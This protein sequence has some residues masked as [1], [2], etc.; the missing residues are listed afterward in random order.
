[1]P[2]KKSVRLAARWFQ[3][4]A[5]EL[6]AFASNAS[7]HLSAEHQ[8]W[9]YEYAI[10]RLYR[11]FEL[12]MLEGIVG[13]INN[14]TET[15]SSNVG[16]PFPTHLT[17]EV[18]E[19]LVLGAGYFDFKGRDGLIRQLRRFVPETH[20]L[21]TL[22]R[23]IKYKKSLEQLSGL[24]NFAAHDSYQ[25]KKAAL[26]AVGLDRIGSAGSWLKRQGRFEQIVLRLKELSQELHDAAPY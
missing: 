20:Y 21:V 9:A 15:F 19:Y 11:E 13:A 2:R 10:I 17:D 26:E 5:D 1:M 14:D 23:K 4:K 22:A 6:A 25:S 7:S 3:S 12:L 18:C 8:S 24:R 16:I